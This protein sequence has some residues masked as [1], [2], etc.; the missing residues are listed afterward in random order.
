MQ[1]KVKNTRPHLVSVDGRL[2]QP[3]EVVTLEVTPNVQ[4]SIKM[5][6]L[7]KIEPQQSQQPKQQSKPATQKVKVKK[8]TKSRT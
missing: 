5:G 2:I 8:E 6:I 4:H 1:V 3:G 7:T